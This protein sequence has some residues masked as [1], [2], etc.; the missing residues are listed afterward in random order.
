L[1]WD[2]GM[3]GRLIAIPD[4]CAG[5]AMRVLPETILAGP[6]VR[7]ALGATGPELA[8]GPVPL[9]LAAAKNGDKPASAKTDP[10]STSHRQL[11]FRFII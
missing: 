7:T 2:I 9:P 10:A 11:R 5:V 4:G 8:A 1:Y 3:L 6:A